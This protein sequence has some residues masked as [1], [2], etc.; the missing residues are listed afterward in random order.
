MRTSLNLLPRM[1]DVR[2]Q[3]STK[4]GQEY[5]LGLGTR[6]TWKK[7]LGK[8]LFF[9]ERKNKDKYRGEKTLLSTCEKKRV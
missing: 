5:S 8:L 4:L 9:C 7:D 6:L 1:W 3:T 2:E